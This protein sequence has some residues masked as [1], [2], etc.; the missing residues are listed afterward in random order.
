MT[1]ALERYTRQGLALQTPTDIVKKRL[2]QYNAQAPARAEAEYQRQEAYKQS[3]QSASPIP[4]PSNPKVEKAPEVVYKGYSY[5]PEVKY[6][7]DQGNVIK[8]ESYSY[9]KS[10]GLVLRDVKNLTTGGFYQVTHYTKDG[11]ILYSGLVDST[12]NVL[13]KENFSRKDYDNKYQ[14]VQR[15]IE[16]GEDI[17]KE[18]EKYAP[19]VLGVTEQQYNR[20]NSLSNQEQMKQFGRVIK[21]TKDEI[22]TM[23]YSAGGTPISKKQYDILSKPVQA[24]DDMIQGSFLG[25]KEERLEQYKRMGYSTEEAERL[26]NIEVNTALSPEVAQR[27]EKALKQEEVKNVLTNID[28][29]TGGGVPEQSKKLAPTDN[30]FSTNVNNIIAK[31]PKAWERA[32]EFIGSTPIASFTA[33]NFFGINTGKAL[34]KYTISDL[35][36]RVGAEL[37]SGVNIIQKAQTNIEQLPKGNLNRLALPILITSKTVLGAGA[38]AV[39]LIARRPLLAPTVYGAGK[40]IGTIGTMLPTTSTIVGGVMT[41]KYIGEAITKYKTIKTSLGKSKFIGEEALIFGV[42]G[43]GMKKPLNLEP[44][45]SPIRYAYAKL[46]GNTKLALINP[47]QVQTQTTLGKIKSRYEQ[48]STAGERESARNL[49]MERTGI[50]LAKTTKTINPNTIKVTPYDYAVNIKNKGLIELRQGDIY[51]KAGIF[52][53]AQANIPKPII[54]ISSKYGTGKFQKQ[55]IESSF[56]AQL[57]IAHEIIHY[58]TEPLFGKIWNIEKRIPELKR[59]SEILAY[60]LESKYAKS[61]FKLNLKDIKIK[62]E[63]YK[64]ANIIEKH[65][66]SIHGKKTTIFD[67]R[68]VTTQTTIYGKPASITLKQGNEL[69]T[70]PAKP[71]PLLKDLIGK[72]IVKGV[73][74]AR[75]D[76][77]G[78]RP[79]YSK[80]LDTP[81]K[82]KEIG[83]IDT[84]LSFIDKPKFVVKDL[85]TGKVRITPDIK[86]TEQ[87]TFIKKGK[88]YVEIAGTKVIAQISPEQ[89]AF[90]LAVKLREKQFSIS[91]LNKQ[92]PLFDFDTITKTQ[93]LFNFLE[94]PIKLKQPKI[95]FSKQ[96]PIILK[97]KKE[98]LR[99]FSKQGAGGTGTFKGQSLVTT[100]KQENYYQPM[101]E[102]LRGATRVEPVFRGIEQTYGAKPLEIFNQKQNSLITTKQKYLTQL[103]NKQ[104][105]L[106]AIKYKQDYFGGLIIKQKSLLEET[107]LSMN[108]N[109]FKQEQI[110]STINAQD[111]GLESITLLDLEQATKQESITKQITQKITKTQLKEKLR[112]NIKERLGEIIII[113]PILRGSASQDLFGMQR[114]QAYN[115]LVKLKQL[116]AKKGHYIARGYKKVNEQPLTKES[117]LGLGAGIV[118]TYANRSY[119]IVPVKGTPQQRYDLSNQWES[120][121]GKFRTAK[122]NPNVLVEKSTYAIDNPMEIKQIPYEAIRQRRNKS[123]F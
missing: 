122:R 90:K 43:A 33:T 20:I 112:L 100:Q 92:A 115:V 64:K 7:D 26:S 52:T 61:G 113:P 66:I 38:G 91:G 117:A 49:F 71:K 111:S 102:Y 96:N 110:P 79:V 68:P 29:I 59:P 54:T 119:K 74:L 123:W 58:K 89:R 6:L 94:K 37:E 34:D 45:K 65:E 67:E 16:K 46:T 44:I 82:Y 24:N 80:Y 53:P 105:A 83:S 50:D 30:S 57:T 60:S 23:A 17:P 12:G 93:R 120:L 116:K 51:P 11:D 121:K 97:A 31:I 14:N 13:K 109:I 88:Q 70:Y 41:G 95:D 4:L 76:V 9:S 1:T 107:N 118:D 5:S 114:Q 19:K 22:P 15:A 62:I 10:T 108:M 86:T 32:N 2:E 78:L 18:L 99:M 84:R 98:K 63:P 55:F 72:E 81:I 69:I 21:P 28:I 56:E 36:F 40:V 35:G 85:Q 87:G 103:K 25:T 42:L 3:I 8:T 75:V 27:F 104:M 47:I 39:E 48:G 101:T 77:S 106:T 73:T